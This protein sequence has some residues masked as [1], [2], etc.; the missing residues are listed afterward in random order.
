MR[1]VF[2]EAVQ[3]YGGARKST[4]ELAYS[5]KAKHDVTIVDAWGCCEE[6]VSATGEKGLDLII[7]NPSEAPVTLESTNVF[8]KILKIIRFIKEHLYLK[9]LL[10]EKLKTI[11]PDIVIVNNPKTLSLV[12]NKSKF[13]TI[14]FAREWMIP[15][16]IKKRNK[17]LF[18]KKVDGFICVAQASKHALYCG[19]IAKLSNIFV[20]PNAIETVEKVKHYSDKLI[21]MHCGGFLSSK[22]QLTILEIAKELK[23]SISDFKIY[24]VGIVYT[25]KQSKIFLRKIKEQ[26]IDFNLEDNIEIV[27]DAKKMDLYYAET[28]ILLHPSDTEGLPRVVMEAMANKVAVIANPVGGVN[29]FILDGFT[30]FLTNHNDVEDYVNRI[31][32]LHDDTVLFENITANAYRLIK[33]NY[34]KDLQVNKFENAINKIAKKV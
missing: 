12:P 22:G 28:K 14:F 26:I 16:S 9:R 30:G 11:L 23:K 3:T 6:F 25:S 4:V 17:L 18:K 24:M 32:Q 29:D 1:I 27:I 10:K 8:N 15:K 19:N 5:L 31:I 33:T 34:V 13:K 7:L 20:V 2:L 21:L